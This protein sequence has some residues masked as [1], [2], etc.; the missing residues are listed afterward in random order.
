MSEAAGSGTVHIIDDDDAVRESVG[1]LCQSA[2]LKAETYAS[3]MAFLQVAPSLSGG[4]I[5]TDVRM[6]EMD[7][8]TLVRHLRDR[9]VPLPIIVMTG[10]GDV[11]MA[12]QAMREGAVD[13]LE[14]PF[15]DEVMLGSIR[16]ALANGGR[17]PR[18][19]DGDDPTAAKLALLSE[20]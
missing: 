18:T 15:D 4:C 10:H 13:F 16:D 20:R 6:P 3:P 17:G 12:V 8:L 5:L 1:F 9:A 14:K 19:V 2:G 7:G 11:P